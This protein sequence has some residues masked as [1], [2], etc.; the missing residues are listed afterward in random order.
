MT[1]VLEI[2][3]AIVVIVGAIFL[4]RRRAKANRAQPAGE[5]PKK[6][7]RK[8]TDTKAFRQY[9]HGDISHDT[10]REILEGNQKEGK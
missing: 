5:A 8:I 4:S 3:A 2:A 9:A 10:Y 6:N 7:R 1:L